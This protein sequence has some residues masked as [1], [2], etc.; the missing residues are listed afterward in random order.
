MMA[1]A[2]ASAGGTCLRR[3]SSRRPTISGMCHEDITI[4]IAYMVS[5]MVD[6]LKP[7]QNFRKARR[8]SSDAGR[9]VIKVSPT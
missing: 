2:I 5:L 3:I 6:E 9:K 8:A 1:I 4:Q 7:V